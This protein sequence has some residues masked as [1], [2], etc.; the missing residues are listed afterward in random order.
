MLC[1]GL[2]LGGDV[3]VLLVILLPGSQIGLRKATTWVCI[4]IYPWSL[5]T[6]AMRLVCAR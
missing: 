1:S 5:P 2:L 6:V 4:S 3:S